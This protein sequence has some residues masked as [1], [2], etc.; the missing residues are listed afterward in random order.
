MQ[1]RILTCHEMFWSTLPKKKKKCFGL[2]SSLSWYSSHYSVYSGSLVPYQAF[3]VPFLAFLLQSFSASHLSSCFFSMVIA[4]V[5]I[6][7]YLNQGF[8]NFMIPVN[9]P[10]TSSL[11]FCLVL[12]IP[13]TVLFLNHVL[14]SSVS[15]LF[16]VQRIWRIIWSMWS[17]YGV[18]CSG[19][20]SLCFKVLWS[21]T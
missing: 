12:T 9:I 7:K 6:S 11:F 4:T 20:C 21:L 8:H 1:I 2:C 10:L 13:T 18:S 16:R 15:R 14:W 5:N 3:P 19:W 17:V